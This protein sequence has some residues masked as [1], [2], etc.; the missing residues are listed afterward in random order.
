MR[1]NQAHGAVGPSQ[2][3][4]LARVRVRA[5]ALR[6]ADGPDEAHRPSPARRELRRRR[7]DA[8]AARV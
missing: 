8:S 7:A 6:P 1:T 3:G 5:R 2:D 4:P